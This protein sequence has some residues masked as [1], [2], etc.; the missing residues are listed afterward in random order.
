MAARRVCI[1]GI[2]IVSPLGSDRDTTW[3]RVL[4]GDSG[5]GPI[6]QFHATT[7]PTTFACE[8]TGFALSPAAIPEAHRP[9]LNR[10]SEF[11]VQAALEAMADAGFT[12]GDAST[13]RL[14]D[15]CGYDSERFGVSIGAS[16]GAISPHHLASMLAGMEVKEGLPDLSSKVESA[17]EGT[18][19]VMKNHP[20]TLAALLSARWSAL[21]PVTTIHTACASSGQSLGQ[22]YLQIKRGEADVMLAGGADSLAG[23]LLLAG[24]CLLGALS[25]R[26]DDPQAASRPFDKGRDGFVASEGAAMLILEEY[27]RAK[28]RGARIYGEFAGYGET[29]SAYRI[30][31]LPEN[32]RGIVEAMALA[33]KDAK[34]AVEDVHYINAHGTS[35]ELNDRVEALAVRRLF[36]ARGA[37]PMISSTKSETGHLISAAGAMEAAFTALCVYEG[38]VP[39]TRN[40]YNTDCGDD[41]DFVAGKMREAPVYAALSNSIGFGGSNSVVAIKRHEA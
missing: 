24:F 4:A 8:V 29:E 25:R 5:A 37:K 40:L 18:H 17:R 2:G 10:P 20:G 21:G 36:G 19:I 27:G 15:L 38:R 33:I 22:A 31:D 28:A 3:R 13:L 11:G 39:P 16:I 26:N 12:A 41:L 6:T 35:T 7:W 30:T 23:E 14:P 32:G 34:I 1:T 9:Y